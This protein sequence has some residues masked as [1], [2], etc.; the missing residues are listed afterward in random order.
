MADNYP[1]EIYIPFAKFSCRSYPLNGLKFHS[2]HGSKRSYKPNPNPKPKAGLDQESPGAKSLEPN[3][4]L[5]RP[6]PPQQEFPCRSYALNNRFLCKFQAPNHHFLCRFQPSKHEFPCRFYTLDN[7]FWVQFQAQTIFFHALSSLGGLRTTIFLSAPA[8]QP[9]INPFV[10]PTLQTKLSLLI[11]SSGQCCSFLLESGRHILLALPKST[12]RELRQMGGRKANHGIVVQWKITARRTGPGGIRTLAVRLEDLPK[13]IPRGPRDVTSRMHIL[14]ESWYLDDTMNSH[15]AISAGGSHF[16]AV[17]RKLLSGT[18][19]VLAEIRAPVLKSGRLASSYNG[20]QGWIVPS[21]NGF[22]GWIAPSYN[23]FQRWIAPSYNGFQGWIAP[24]YNGCQG[25]IAPS[26]NGFQGWI[27]PSYNGFQGWI[28]PSYNG[29]QGWIAPSYN[30]FQGWIAP[31][32]NGFQGRTAPS[33]KGFQGWIA[34][35][36]KGFQDWTAPS[37]NGFQGRILLP[38]MV[39]KGRLHLSTRAFKRGSSLLI[40]VCKAAE[41]KS[42]QVTSTKRQNAPNEEQLNHG[43][44]K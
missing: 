41:R 4:F 12:K 20:F 17:R 13:K 8:F 1:L 2:E 10:D 31:S 38:A 32:Y 43:I 11:Q 39:F 34:P 6:Q 23:G 30:G 22:Q 18:F 3:H 29:F 36:Y 24:S 21:F 44:E 33:Y 25:W 19:P 26:F 28:A 5:C 42:R 15:F 14:E 37:D 9:R 7:H 16:R 27:A 35:S 40:V